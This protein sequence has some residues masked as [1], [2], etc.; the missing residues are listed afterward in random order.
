MIN[1][2]NWISIT[3]AGL[4]AAVLTPR[5]ALAAGGIPAEADTSALI[6]L[7][8]IKSDGQESRCQS[9][10]WFA[11]AQ[12]SLYVVTAADAW[13]ARAV[14]KG[15]NRT[16]IWVGD[17]GTWGSDQRYKKLPQV[18]ASSSLVLSGSARARSFCSSRS[19]F[20]LNNCTVL[21]SKY[22]NSL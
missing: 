2:R 13:R 18:M 1:R 8:P 9:E 17:V 3:T 10:I 14:G 20:R 6:Y 11:R 7:T 5:L 19:S 16:R 15:L 12:N 22:S 21:F 4:S